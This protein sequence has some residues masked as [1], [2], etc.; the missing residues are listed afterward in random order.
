[1]AKEHIEDHADKG[2][3]K[4]AKLNESKKRHSIV[5]PVLFIMA[6]LAILA[7]AVAAMTG[8]PKG[9][10]FEG[11]NRAKALA[12]LGAGESLKLGIDRVTLGNGLRAADV[13]LSVGAGENQLFSPVGGGIAPPSVGMANN[14]MADKWL[15]PKGIVVGLGLGTNRAMLAVL[16]V[17]SGVCAEVNEK[18]TGTP[19]VPEKS[20][21]GDFAAGVVSA[22][23]GAWPAPIAS[24]FAGCV[25]NASVSVGEEGPTS[26]YFF[27][28]V[29]AVQ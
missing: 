12:L 1:M 16:P 5:G 11:V 7:A 29:L 17:S 13:D 28:Q 18:S 21:L 22:A 23:Y 8:T 14:P 20:D 10:A 6:V 19:F 4:T 3:E 25:Q 27:Y 24:S 26:A 15:Y 2:I 9:A